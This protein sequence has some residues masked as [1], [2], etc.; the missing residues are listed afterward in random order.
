MNFWIIQAQENPAESKQISNRR[1]W[2][3]NTLSEVLADRGHYVVRWRS[4]FSHQKK[5]QLVNGSVFEEKENYFH[6]FIESSPY[7]SH[8]GLARIRN[9]AELGK[10]FTKLSQSYSKK[11]DAIHVG[12]V[13]IELCRAVIEYGKKQQI[14]VIVD[15]RDLWPD[16]Y[17]EFIP[18]KLSFLKP[19]TLRLLNAFSIGLKK[20]FKDATGFTALTDSYLDWALRKAGRKK[21]ECDKVFPMS[22]QA[23]NGKPS[24]KNLKQIRNK[25]GLLES[26]L[27]GCYIGNIGYQSDFDTIIGA[28]RQL[29]QT[30]KNFKIL[31]AGSGPQVETIIENSS[32]VENFIFTGWLDSNELH[33]LLSISQIGF[34]AY[35]SVPNFLLNIPNKF[36]EY[37]AGRMAIACGI[38]GE[39]GNLVKQHQC[40]FT[41]RAGQIEELTKNLIEL[42]ECPDV[43][44]KMQKNAELL[45]KE[46]FDGSEIYPQFADYLERV[47]RAPSK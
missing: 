37:L 13:P 18:E 20:A 4:S 28:A 25:F 33:A 34:I 39:M 1:E 29:K 38:E 6:Q 44:L 27:I 14:P 31:V 19:I 42:I 43:L 11:P 36:S 41:Y 32:D 21:Q 40:G 12:N 17:V 35:K 15:I 46:K 47:T 3:S 45:H 8:V 9:H 23:L 10:N 5:E 7:K 26:D 22:Y 16:T 24:K 30:H 2:R